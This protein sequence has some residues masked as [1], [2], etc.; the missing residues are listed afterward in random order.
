[1]NQIDSYEA[2]WMLEEHFEKA[3]ECPAKISSEMANQIR[4]LCKHAFNALGCRDW[5]RIDVR[6]GKH[7]TQYILEV[8]SPPGML[9]K[10]EDYS[11]YPLA[12]RAA[13]VDFNALV[14]KLIDT[15]AKRHS[16]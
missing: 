16:F 10:P 13:G 5:A 4:Y 8:N 6:L 2:K 11:R 7:G 12:A 3:V 14:G 15:A 9:P 1:M